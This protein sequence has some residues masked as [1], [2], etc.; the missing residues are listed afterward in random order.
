MNPVNTT[1]RLVELELLNFLCDL[2]WIREK[3]RV[4]AAHFRADW[5]IGRRI[6]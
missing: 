3:K 6:G 4:D 2:V 1:E 5:G